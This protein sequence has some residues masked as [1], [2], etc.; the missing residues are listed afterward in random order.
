M[1]AEKDI[2]GDKYDS[3]SDVSTKK[4]VWIDDVRQAPP[5]FI[6]FKTVNGFK[7]YG[8]QFGYQ[9]IDFIDTDHDA[10]ECQKYGGDY[11]KCFEYL[12]DLGV[13]NL[14][15][16]IHSSNPVGACAI[17]EIISYCKD[18]DM[19]WREVRNTSESADGKTYAY[20]CTRIN[21]QRIK[22]EGFIASHG[23]YTEENQFDDLYDEYLPSNP[24]FVSKSPWS[25]N[26]DS[27]DVYVIKMDITGLEIYPDFGHISDVCMYD[28]DY[29][30]YIPTGDENGW[31]VKEYP[32]AMEYLKKHGYLLSLD[33]I[34]EN[35][36]EIF[37]AFETCVVDGDE[38]T[39]D[40]IVSW[41]TMD[42]F[43]ADE[44]KEETDMTTDRQIVDE[45]KKT[46]LA[47]YKD[48]PNVKDVV[49]RFWELKKRISGQENDIDWWI[50][51]PFS[52]LE[53]FVNNYDTR[54]KSE[55]KQDKY[56]QN[57]Q[58]YGAVRLGDVGEYEVWFVPTHE[59]AM[60][61]GRFYKGITVKWCISTEN[62]QF[63][64]GTYGD[65]EFCFA[66]R[67]EPIGDRF[68]KLAFQFEGKYDDLTI[69]DTQD[70]DNTFD[71]EE[72]IDKVEDM[73]KSSELSRDGATE[74]MITNVLNNVESEE[75]QQWLRANVLDH[76]SYVRDGGSNLLYAKSIDEFDGSMFAENGNVDWDEIKEIFKGDDEIFTRSVI[77]NENIED[78]DDTI[79]KDFDDR[80][81]DYGITWEDLYQKFKD[82]NLDS[83]IEE[84]MNDDFADGLGY[85]TIYTTCRVNAIYKNGLDAIKGILDDI[86]FVREVKYNDD[87]KVMM[88]F[89]VP[90]DVAP[91]LIKDKIGPKYEK[92]FEVVCY[93][94][95]MDTDAPYQVEFQDGVYWGFDDEYMEKCLDQFA[96]K[97]EGYLKKQKD[98]DGQMFFDFDKDYLDNPMN[99]KR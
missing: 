85:Y 97:L 80:M 26:P 78:L 62:P 69:W 40:R 34:V 32:A 41:T 47:K 70:N 45:D 16:H 44:N 95:L 17:R 48:E 99:A 53:K 21:P 18:H 6:W 9:D 11:V 13:R 77:E 90:F 50:K 94:Y 3:I 4:K 61:L 27:K 12:K 10:G 98:I 86:S 7:K 35:P 31:Q 76:V 39:P 15:I 25:I 58:D 20:H 64:N 87:G 93:E 71:D 96:D 88:Y 49:D 92:T 73:F 30:F 36:K 91:E 84:M 46:Y 68:D 51:K 43:K 5:G 8:E 72:V 23:G 42:K 55:R 22:D 82:G 79:T 38:I 54:N 28:E 37:D 65:S 74:K 2:G 52:D 63:F 29:N 60:I 89:E 75:S 59:A 1:E 24:C 14:T 56:A 83:G 67:R 19:N 57:A 66:I 33:Q 81:E